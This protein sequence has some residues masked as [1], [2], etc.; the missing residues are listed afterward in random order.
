MGRTCEAAAMD[1]GFFG[2]FDLRDP[3]VTVCDNPAVVEVEGYWLC[4][5]CCEALDEMHH[6]VETLFTDSQAR[7]AAEAVAREEWQSVA[8]RGTLLA[9]LSGSVVGA[10]ALIGLGP[11]GWVPRLSQVVLVASSAGLLRWA[12]R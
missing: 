11:E 3:L 2:N 12:L 9:V 5:E 6:T 1:A 4:E 10:L 8:V 7:A